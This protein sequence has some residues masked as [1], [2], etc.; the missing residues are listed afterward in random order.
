MRFFSWTLFRYFGLRFI[1]SFLGALLAI[2]SLAFIIDL[3]ELLRDV[4]DREDINFALT[5]QLSL[6][7]MPQ[8][9]E[10]IFPF[11]VLFGAIWTYTRLT[12]SS[13]LVVARAA[14]VSVWQFL[15]PAIVV[16][17][18][19][20]AFIV[21]VFNPVSA[22][23]SSHYDRIYAKHV[24]GKDNQL[25]LSRTGLWLRQGNREGRQSVV[26]AVG[27]NQQDSQSVELDKVMILLYRD[28]D[29]FDGRIDAAKAVLKD[30]KWVL[31]D[32]RVTQG[33]KTSEYHPTFEI[34]TALELRHIEDS[35]AQPKAISFWA[36]PRFI[37]IASDSGFSTLRY[38]LHWHSILS[39]PF[40]LVAMI[41]IA[42]TFSLR[43]SR[44]GG[45]GQLILVG[46]ITGFGLYFVSDVTRAFG[47]SGTVP[48]VL[49]AWAPTAV[50][51]LLGTF[52]LFHLEDG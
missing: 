22:Q 32:A 9:A 31:F 10:T 23:L 38:Q 50:A 47:L 1:A 35:F 15:T 20:G 41:L 17:F 28:Q 44:L 11:T 26:H 13:E 51:M 27:V 25:Q 18:G 14:G 43:H 4:A 52:M 37:Q 8:L 36:L 12:K 46:T 45:V 49:A 19:T 29:R 33:A 7:K 6:L 30:K 40:L 48:V 34:A 2:M 39:Q 24:D 42:A 16:A 5:L 21:T 3:V